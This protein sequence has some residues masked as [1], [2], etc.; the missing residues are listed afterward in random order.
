MATVLFSFLTET[1]K[2]T[3]ESLLK[4]LGNDIIITA[5]K[6]AEVKQVYLGAKTENQVNCDIEKLSQSIKELKQEIQRKNVYID[7]ILDENKGLSI[8]NKQLKKD[9]EAMKAGV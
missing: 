3:E 8:E 1:I 2:E 9:I 5:Q 4:I 6:K 7:I